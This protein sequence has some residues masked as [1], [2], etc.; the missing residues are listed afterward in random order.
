MGSARESERES[1]REG[2]MAGCTV[3]KRVK[4]ERE[5]SARGMRHR[6]VKQGGAEQRRK[7]GREE[8]NKRVNDCRISALKWR[9]VTEK[10]TRER[11]RGRQQPRLHRITDLVGQKKFEEGGE[12]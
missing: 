11:G 7:S 4:E 5:E 8:S 10:K 3:Y 2:E 6:P 1:G 12:E 9:G